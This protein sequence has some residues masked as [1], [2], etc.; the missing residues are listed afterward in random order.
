MTIIRRDCYR[1]EKNS[2]GRKY[3]V[4]KG[5]RIRITGKAKWQGKQGQ[6]EIFYDDL[7][8]SWHAYQTVEVEKHKAKGDKRA[9]VD[10]GRPVQ[11]KHHLKEL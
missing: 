8:K 11:I 9:L 6:L 1:I 4:F 10:V 7:T 3:L 2:K 5:M